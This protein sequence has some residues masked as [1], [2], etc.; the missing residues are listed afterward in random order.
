MRLKLVPQH[1]SIDFLRHCRIAFI[2]SI[3]L[4]ISSFGLFAIKGLNLGIDFKGG[5]LIEA[6][7]NSGPADILGLRKDL[8]EI[9]TTV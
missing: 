1:T 9:F 8:N 7:N 5:I 6:R 4:V 2:F 3:F